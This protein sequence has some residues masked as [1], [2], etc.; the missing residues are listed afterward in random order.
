MHGMK[1]NIFLNSC[2]KFP[3][4]NS[5]RSKALKFNRQLLKLEKKGQS[6][7]PAPHWD[8]RIHHDAAMII[9]NVSMF[10]R[11]AGST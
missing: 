9:A 3:L 10:S 5:Q 6:S 2:T 8:P 1:V 7:K 4:N 11:K